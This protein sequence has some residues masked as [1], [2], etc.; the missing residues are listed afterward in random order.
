MRVVHEF[1]TCSKYQAIYLLAVNELMYLS[2]TDDVKFAFMHNTFLEIDVEPDLS[3][4]N[5]S[6]NI[7]VI[8]VR[9]INR[10]VSIS[11]VGDDFGVYMIVCQ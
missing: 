11:C 1:A 5:K 4:Q 2:R 9:I 7:A 3:G 10:V 6:E 8:A